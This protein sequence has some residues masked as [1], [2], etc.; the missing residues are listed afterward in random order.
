MLFMFLACASEPAPS[1]SPASA[2]NAAPAEAPKAALREES[3]QDLAAAQKAGAIT[4][5]DVRTP[6]E[7]AE[8][9]VAGAINI[10]VD[11]VASRLSEIPSTGDVH[12]ICAVGGRSLQATKTLTAKGV[13][14]INVKGGTNAWIA[15]GLPVEK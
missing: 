4:L 7:Y 3:V 9:H 5:I 12:V 10:P 14:A 13:A 11:Q 15:A 8:G 2:P 6:G 1:A